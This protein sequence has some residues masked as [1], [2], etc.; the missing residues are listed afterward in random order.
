MK[1]EADRDNFLSFCDLIFDLMDEFNISVSSWI[2][3]P[4]HNKDVGGKINSNHLDGLG[5]D[6]ILDNPKDKAKFCKRV[7]EMG[8]HWLDESDHIHVQV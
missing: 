5:L 1:S 7:N 4:K 6:I 8:L 2:R 3:T